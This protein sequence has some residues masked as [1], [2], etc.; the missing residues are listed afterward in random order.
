MNKSIYEFDEKK[1]LFGKKF[2]I[3]LS[4][5]TLDRKKY[6]RETI[7]KIVTN[8]EVVFDYLELDFLNASIAKFNK[9]NDVVNF[10]NSKRNVYEK[11]T[12]LFL[13]NFERLSYKKELLETL[14]NMNGIKILMYTYNVNQLMD[15]NIKYDVIYILSRSYADIRLLNGSY[16]FELYFSDGFPENIYTF[17]D[18]FI[19]F[20]AFYSTLYEILIS[21]NIRN[22]DSFH[23]LILYLLENIG[24]PINALAV[25]EYF[26][27]EDYNF[28][29]D[30]I[31]SYLQILTTN[32]LFFQVNRFD[33]VLD[34][35]LK[36]SPSYFVFDHGL[37]EV[38]LHNNV[39][40]KVNTAKNIVYLELIRR[41]FKVYI[42]KF[43]NFVISFYATKDNNNYYFNIID[44]IDNYDEYLESFVSLTKIRD[45]G[46]KY[47]IS[48]DKFFY[49]DKK[50]IHINLEDFLLLDSI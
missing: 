9:V 40:D 6:F 17:N 7:K 38:I 48:F 39:I 25:R 23:K 20:D 37:K 32:Y 50:V 21:N 12:Y 4:F 24:N 41:G 16:S 28:S 33:L 45:I 31:I 34:K 42:G 5:K 29:V 3:I 13:F 27:S 19:I 2:K 10:I 11:Y 36:T 18:D 49:V 47:L 30:T 26:L 22:V 35:E 14:N 46:L 8:T 1:Y 43:Y 15:S 44:S